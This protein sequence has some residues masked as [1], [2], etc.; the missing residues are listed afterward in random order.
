MKTF[1]LSIQARKAFATDENEQ[2]VYARA[3]WDKNEADKDNALMRESDP[4]A[5]NEVWPI[6]EDGDLYDMYINEV[7]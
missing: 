2:I 7:E 6:D 5:T 4:T 3:F 1:Y